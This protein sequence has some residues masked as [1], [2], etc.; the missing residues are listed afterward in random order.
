MRSTQSRWI[1]S[2]LGRVIGDDATVAQADD[3]LGVS[4]DILFVRHD[5]DGLPG[6]VQILEE[7]D[8]LDRGLR[9]EVAGGFVGQQDTGVVDERPGDRDALALPARE[10]VGSMGHPVAEPDER[11]GGFGFFACALKLVLE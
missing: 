3:P 5:D 10:L 8:D 2:S 4:G 9:I 6:L 11:E 7:V 1:G